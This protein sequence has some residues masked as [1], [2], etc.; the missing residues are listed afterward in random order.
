MNLKFQFLLIAFC[1]VNFLNSQENGEDF[2]LPNTTQ[3]EAYTLIITTNVNQGNR[4]FSG[5]LSLQVRVVEDTNEI[6][7][8]SRDHT[9]LEHQLYNM[10]R[11][12]LP[13]DGVNLERTG[14]VIKIT[15][16]QTLQAGLL[17]DL[18]ISYQG[19]L[20]LLSDGFFRSEYVVKESGN[21]FDLY[22]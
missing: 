14:D 6:S 17:Y 15:S 2:V 4:K 7:L 13:L 18:H 12:E 5:V 9:I 21:D 1:F 20:L 8:H 10:A 19:N 3:P 11:P 22:R 16:E